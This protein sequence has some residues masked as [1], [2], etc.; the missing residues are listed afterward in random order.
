MEQVRR[1]EHGVGQQRF[2]PP[3]LVLQRLQ[4]LGPQVIEAPDGERYFT[5]SRTVRR[6]SDLQA[7]LEDELVVG[8]GCELKYAGKLVQAAGSTSPRRRSSRSSRRAGSAS[9]QPV[10]NARPP[11]SIAPS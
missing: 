4:P 9:G 10:P 8:L 2:E 1:V 5:L 7:G 11:R 6:V 3:V